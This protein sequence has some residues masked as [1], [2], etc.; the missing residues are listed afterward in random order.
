L[1]GSPAWPVTAKKIILHVQ[2]AARVLSC[3]HF[4]LLL[5]VI[6]YS[7]LAMSKSVAVQY[8]ER[9]FLLNYDFDKETDGKSEISAIR[10]SFNEFA[11]E[12]D[13]FSNK[14]LTHFPTF[15]AYNVN[16]QK[17]VQ[18]GQKCRVDPTDVLNLKFWPMKSPPKCSSDN[19]CY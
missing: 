13:Y 5:Y 1:D 17:F 18:L 12:D 3:F 19:V 10:N 6:L 2:I 4:E 9:L 16:I 7:S 11:S 14:L 8:N 15:E